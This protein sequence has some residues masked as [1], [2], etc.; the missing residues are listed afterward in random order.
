MGGDRVKDCNGL[1]QNITGIRLI[2]SEWM[3]T[4]RFMFV[5]PPPEEV[6]TGGW[7]SICQWA[8]NHTVVV[9]CGT[10]KIKEFQSLIP[11]RE[12]E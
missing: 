2:V 9:I 3:P 12:V 11:D 5:P 4:D 8:K 10:E 1:I 6:C 7:E